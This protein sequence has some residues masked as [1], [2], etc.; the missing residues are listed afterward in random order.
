MSKRHFGSVEGVN[1]GQEF[2]G[3]KQLHAAGIHTGLQ[4]GISWEIDGCADSIV[5]SGGYEDDRDEGD[6]ILYTGHGGRDQTTGRQVRHQAFTE[7]NEALQKN[8]QQG[9]PVRVTRGADLASTYAPI[10]GYRYDG[11]YRVEHCWS[12]TG[13]SGFSVCRFLLKRQPGQPVTWSKQ[14][15]QDHAALYQLAKAASQQ[16]EAATIHPIS[17]FS[18][19]PD[20]PQCAVNQLVRIKNIVGIVVSAAPDGESFQL[21][22]RA[23]GDLK[24]FVSKFLRTNS[25]NGPSSP[26]A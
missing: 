12:E 5:L 16:Y 3:R 17:E 1:V 25:S 4:A 9:V 21:K 6:V 26:V 15:E 18:G 24:K 20:F 14:T 2:E 10:S 8:M 7:G 19:R 11:L 13:L 23:T 22:D